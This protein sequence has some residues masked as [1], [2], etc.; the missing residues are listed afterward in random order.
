MTKNKKSQNFAPF[1][2]LVILP[3]LA[4]LISFF[5][6]FKGVKNYVTTS[7]YFRIRELK[8]EGLTDK[9]YLDLMK[10]E[11]LGVNIFRLD[12]AKIA[13]RIKI[14]FPT[15][16]SVTIKRVLPS[17]LLVV[18]KERL[19][20]ALIKRDLYY[21]LDAD[22]MVL[23]SF[24]SGETLTFPLIVGLEN[25]LPRF[26]PGVAY[27]TGALHRALILAKTLRAQAHQIEASLP[28]SQRRGI[29]KIDA[30]DPH[31][32]SF[33]LGDDLRVGVGDSDFDN[34]IDLLPIILQSIG[35]DL[36]NVKYIDL[37]PREPVVA[38]KD[39]KRKNKY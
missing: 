18:A 14:R 35:A 10:E 19:P 25:R 9:R 21:L 37:R 12:V 38:M 28:P 11:V 7:N 36:V 26:T 1:F 23:A 6:I 39:E 16:Y 31:Q 20:V 32:L 24:S 4:I 34:K 2:L 29:T 8:V 27:S 22:G 17:Q 5:A 13:E 33:Y 3:L 15:F 30:G